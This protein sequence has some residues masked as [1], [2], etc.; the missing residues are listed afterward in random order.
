[1][2]DVLRAL[3]V[4]D[5]EQDAG[6]IARALRRRYREL[7]LELVQDA[8]SLRAALARGAWDVV[9][10]DWSMPGFDGA[11]AFA[12]VRETGPDLPFIIVSGSIG[13]ERAV[14]ALRAGADDFVLK[15][16]L[17]GLVPAM[18]RGIR[19]R[20][21]QAE[22]RQQRS[23]AEADLLRA[24]NELE[25][26]VARR[27]EELHVANEAL[28]RA[29]EAAEVANRAKSAFLANMSHE[30]R[31]PM[32]AILGYSQLLQR[33]PGLDAEQ[34][35]YLEIIGRSG[36]HL[37]D[38][39][40]D[41][42]EMSKIEAGH[43]KLNLGTVDLQAMLGDLGRMFRLRADEKGL[44]FEIQRSPGVPRYVSSDEGKL[45]QVLVNLLGNAMKF[46]QRG[47]V[48]VRVDSRPTRAGGQ[49][50]AADVADT[51]PG[52]AAAEIGELFRPFAQTRTGIDAQGGTGLGLALSRE[53]AR[54]MGGDITVE[55]AV[56]AGSVFRFAIPIEVVEQPPS[57][58]AAPSSRRVVGLFGEG[59]PPRVLTVDDH[60]ENRVWLS[61]LL[62]QI[63]FDVRRAANGAEALDV[64]DTWAPHVVLMDLHMP[65]MDG[66]T[67]MR[68][69]RAR[70]AGRATAIVAVTASAFDDTREAIFEAGA[71]GWLRKPVHEAQVLAEIERLIGVQYRYLAPYVRS[72][73]PA[74]PM[75]A[76]R[77]GAAAPLPPGLR[78]SMRDAA[79][80][81]D[82]DGLRELIETIPPEAAAVAAELRELLDRYA[83]EGIE[84]HLAT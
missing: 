52:I 84:R 46:T 80:A 6:L 15:D 60:E 33:S 35:N 68:A 42:L 72:L 49:E 75:R 65:V 8:G 34:R 22:L 3:L 45:R 5:S 70:P 39:I 1:M 31:T 9:L 10:S 48:V 12:L 30:I 47:G 40:N 44:S 56:G 57:P 37:L 13:E 61:L 27:T 59:S 71:D 38:L 16:R 76:V 53:F 41:V 32:N 77:P 55:S 79:R 63:G 28:A 29:K 21:V 66:F 50:L 25:T 4:E 18:E 26:R 20:K 11:A 81:A 2:T 62:Q 19:E 58:R 24:R 43:R 23:E 69:I 74:Q 36:D 78:E 51:G 67:A 17:A 14:E 83:Y 73:S 54:L 82:F 64:F 7:H